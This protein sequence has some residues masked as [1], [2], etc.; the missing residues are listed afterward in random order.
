LTRN[1]RI[2]IQGAQRMLL[3]D[4]AAAHVRP[5]GRLVYAV[6]SILPSEGADQVAAFLAAN[7]GWRAI[8]A[9]KAWREALGSEAPFDGPHM[10]LTPHRHRTDGFFVAV[11][12]PP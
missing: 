2:N 11:L 1:W 9:D 10:L 5:N 7:E 8:P 3:D 12:A 4:D 6:C